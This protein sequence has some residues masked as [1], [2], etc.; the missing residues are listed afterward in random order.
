M[1]TKK[2][3]LAR[4]CSWTRVS[5][6]NGS[7]KLAIA[8][9]KPERKRFSGNLVAIL[10]SRVSILDYSPRN[11]V[12][13]FFILFCELGEMSCLELRAFSVDFGCFPKVRMSSNS[14]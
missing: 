11:L 3:G 13:F 9:L 14:L 8:E 10:K 12:F 4:L 2:G 7:S 6:I 1:F 5:A